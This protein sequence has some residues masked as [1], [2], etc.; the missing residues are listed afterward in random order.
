MSM[1]PKFFDLAQSTYLVTLSICSQASAADPAT[2]AR[3][4]ILSTHNPGIARRNRVIQ[5]VG[6]RHEFRPAGV[7]LPFTSHTRPE[8]QYYTHG[9]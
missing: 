4:L 9:S 6:L 3:I 8:P 1:T 2:V 7:S 5:G